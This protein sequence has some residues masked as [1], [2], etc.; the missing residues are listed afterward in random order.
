MDEIRA[1]AEDCRNWGK[2]GDADELGTLNYVTGATVTA[3]KDEIRT[4]ESLGLAIDVGASGPQNN[5]HGRRFNPIHWMLSTGTEA[6]ALG[7]LCGY[8]D[9]VIEMP[10]HGA[11]H[12]D[13][14]GHVFYEG[15]MWNGYD[16][17]MC[18]VAGTSKNSITMCRDRL[19]GRGVLA[20]IAR[21]KGVDALRPGE[22]ILASDL[23]ACLDE[24]RVELH[25]GD[26]L[27]IRTGQL[28]KCQREG[29][30]NY[31]FGDAPGLSLDTARWIKRSA[32]AALATDTFGA[33]V[34]PNETTEMTQPWHH[35][36]IPNV[37]ITVGETFAL[38]RL[39]DACAGDGR[40]AFFVAA[41]ALPIEGGTGTPVNPIAVR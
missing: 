34:R 15:A 32:I 19:V 9:D 5:G 28:G 24:E 8:A 22:G 37:G 30:G 41:G 33:E 36:V 11:T 16:M 21:W 20:D 18:G 13:G 39:A 2:W 31:V 6:H 35:V 23:E 14:L 25:E 1:M 40:Y 29:W 27:F 12:W 38:D 7:N 10:I 3:A 4:G 26:F 17:R